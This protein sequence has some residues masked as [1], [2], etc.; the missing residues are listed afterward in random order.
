[1]SYVDGYVVPVPKANIEAYRAMATKAGKIWREHGALEY[2]ECV[3]DDVKSGE[4]TSFPQA[5]KLKD[6]ET[7]IF[8]YI[9]FESRQHRDEVNAKVMSDP[10][11]A[12]MMDPKTMPFDGKRMFWG[13][14]S[15]LVEL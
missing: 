13:G 12:D 10:R 11:L 4:V 15:P 7:V 1:M 5:V 3:A 9:V 8:S 14:F 2:R 6:D